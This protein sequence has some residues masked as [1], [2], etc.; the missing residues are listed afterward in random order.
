V[1]APLRADVPLRVLIIED[2][3]SDA[4]LEVRALENAGYRVTPVVTETAE[5]MKAALA[6]QAFDVVL[7]DNSLPH[8][9][10]IGALAVLKE[11]GLDIPLIVVSGTMDDE[12]AVELVKAGADDYVLKDRMFRL[13]VVVERALAA[14]EERLRRGQADE[15]RL[16]LEHRLAQSQKLESLGQLAGG[17]AHDF[18]NLLTSILGYSELILASGSSSVDEVRPDLEQIKLA[19]ERARVLTQQILAFSRRQALRP[20]VVF[21][22]QVLRGIEPLLRR[23]IGEDIDLQIT[24]SPGL[25]PVEVDPHQFEQVVMNLVVNARDAMPS[26]GRLTL[27]TATEEVG[28]EFCRTHARAAPGSSV[29]LRVSDTGVGMDAATQERI[30]EP[31]FTTKA[32]GAGTGLGLATVY[33]IVRQSN[34]SIV[35]T[36]E[37][38]RGSTFAIY[39]P[40]AAQPEVPKELPIP[41]KAPAG[42]HETVMVVEDEEALRG[43]IGR[44]LGAAGY[45]TLIFGSAQEALAALE[46]GEPVV[47]LLLTDVMLAGPIQGNDLTRTIR[48]SRPHL[49]VLYVSGYSRDALVHAGRLDE[50]VNLLEKPF[51]P[52]GLANMVREVLDLPRGS[53]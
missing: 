15:E 39:L 10:T 43:L 31:F 40:P 18:N 28:E 36:S 30:F 5:G 14:A 8:F 16:S 17:I 48:A 50:G 34:G 6:E 52:K 27:E 4:A 38:G 23:S 42:G 12:A 7:A 2:S 9:D 21:L 45:R 13:A 53:G 46:Q 32:V 37:P 25:P 19:G 3:P 20:Q 26:G 22:D 44:I 49:P 29:M 51:T 11:T 47:D 33:G 35:V 24:E 41:P 1:D